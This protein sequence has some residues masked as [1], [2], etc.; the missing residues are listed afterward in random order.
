MKL[1]SAVQYFFC[2]FQGGT[3]FVDHFC[4]LYLVFVMLLRLFSAALWSPEWNGLPSW[5]LFVISRV[6]LYF[7]IQYSGT[8]VVLDCIDS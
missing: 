4:Y 8:C 2:P 5:L 1:V 3:S 6:I 7:P